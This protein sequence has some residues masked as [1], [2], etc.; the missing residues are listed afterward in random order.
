MTKFGYHLE[1]MSLWKVIHGSCKGVIN[2]QKKTWECHCTGTLSI[3]FRSATSRLPTVYCSVL[4]TA[5]VPCESM[6]HCIIWPMRYFKIHHSGSNI[7]IGGTSLLDICMY[8]V[9]GLHEYHQSHLSR[10]RHSIH[11]ATICHKVSVSYSAVH[12]TLVLDVCVYFIY[13]L[14]IFRFP[15]WIVYKVRCVS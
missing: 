12:L 1:R 6:S 15:R 7:F 9:S 13:K 14:S 5:W 2:V 11:I 4:C 10:S 8:Y 3:C